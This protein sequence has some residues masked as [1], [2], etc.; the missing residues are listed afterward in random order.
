MITRAQLHDFG[1]IHTLDWQPRPGLNVVV[2]TNGAGKTV[3]LKALYVGQRV[4]EAQKRGEERRTLTELAAEKLY[5]TFQCGDFGKLVRRGGPDKARLELALTEGPLRIE[6]E[7]GATRQVEVKGRGLVAREANTLFFPAKEVLSMHAAILR[8]RDELAAFGF[9]DT[10]VDLARALLAPTTRGGN[11]TEFAGARDRLKAHFGGRVEMVPGPPPTWIFK[12]GS[13]KVP[14]GVTS[15]GV[16]KIGILDQ[17]LGNRYLSTSSV[18]IFDEPESALHPDAILLLMDI[19]LKLAGAGMQIFLA[20]HSYFVL[21]ALAVLAGEEGKGAEVGWLSFGDNG[22]TAQ[23]DL[24][25]GLPENPIIQ[26]SIDL[27]NRQIGGW[28][29]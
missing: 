19:L 10:Y 5:W 29:E 16:R 24:R 22:S 1:P 12:Q 15:E 14:L 26:A 18:L 8:G 7:K 25:G 4:V 27:Y 6:I 21:K 20:T 17:L 28:E 2:G 13:S 3:L 9:D 11:F 23:G